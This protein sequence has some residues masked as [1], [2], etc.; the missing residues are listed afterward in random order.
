MHLLPHYFHCC[1]F[2][3]IT[4]RCHIDISFSM[5]LFSLFAFIIFISIFDITP[6]IDIYAF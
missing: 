1:R 2:S 5:P 3:A 6:D 4:P